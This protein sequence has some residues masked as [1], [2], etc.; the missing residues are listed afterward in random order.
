M[1]I[2]DTLHHNDSD[3]LSNNAEPTTWSFEVKG[4]YKK[5]SV[6]YRECGHCAPGPQPAN[7][8]PKAAK[9]L[10]QKYQRAGGFQAQLPRVF[11]I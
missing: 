8:I 1:V 9:R 4:Q 11:D 6:S 7:T 10:S 5:K 3:L 2:Q